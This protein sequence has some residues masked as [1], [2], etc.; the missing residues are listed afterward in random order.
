MPPHLVVKAL[1][2]LEDDLPSLPSCFERSALRTFALGRCKKGFGDSI[3]ASY[4]AQK[5]LK[6]V[7]HL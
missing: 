3:I 2:K 4:I 5:V 1:H 6:H 7:L